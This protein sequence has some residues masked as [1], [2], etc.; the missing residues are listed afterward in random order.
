[1]RQ[2]IKMVVCSFL[3]ISCSN[4]R[5]FNSDVD[6][7]TSNRLHSN[8]LEI[9]N[10]QKEL[11]GEDRK[12]SKENSTLLTR[13]QN[14]HKAVVKLNNSLDTKD[15][16]TALQLV[17]DFI[18]SGFEELRINNQTVIPFDAETPKSLMKLHVAT[19]EAFMIEEQRKKM[20]SMMHLDSIAVVMV[21]SKL[22]V[23]K[24]EKIA[25]KAAIVLFSEYSSTKTMFS[26][27]LINGN[28]LKR[29]K[30]SWEFE[31]M[32]KGKE[33]GPIELHAEAIY[34]DPKV[35]HSVKGKQ[36]VYIQE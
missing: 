18:V 17:N 21:P 32:P 11:Q 5:V 26:K 14:L 20:R 35:G 6:K 28:E 30:D 31:V 34:S 10:I 16:A 3:F 4:D 22:I 15:K 2:F 24:G 1:M 19:L 29:G 33:V 9:D 13:M 23:K 7:L 36:V 12:I 8:Q 27:I 25:G